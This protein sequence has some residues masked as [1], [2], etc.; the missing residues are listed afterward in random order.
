MTLADMVDNQ[1]WEQI[2]QDIDSAAKMQNILRLRGTG[3]GAVN[4]IPTS[5]PP[6]DME[7]YI[8][9]DHNRSEIFNR[10]APGLE[11]MLVANATEAN[12]RA[13]KATL[14]DLT[15]YPLLLLF[16]ETLTHQVLWRYYGK[17]Y[18]LVP[19]DIRVTDRVLELTER[20]KHGEALTVDEYRAL[21][22]D[23]PYPDPEIGK[24]PFV[25]LKTRSFFTTPPDNPTG[26]AGAT[27]AALPVEAANNLTDVTAQQGQASA[28][29][30]I[31]PAMMEL[32]KWERLANRSAVK[33]IDF[34]AHNIPARVADS[35]RDQL[36]G[37]G[38]DVDDIFSMARNSL[39]SENSTILTLA[40]AINRLA[41]KK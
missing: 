19:D 15:V 24:I 4:W 36:R 28:K 8:G 27:A 6:K 26:D 5:V 12:A 13:G 30:D 29:A 22:K 17:Q 3:S 33:A 37:G 2:G 11:S 21:W 1:Q 14:I 35:V 25:Q 9:R 32:E 20:E 38:V 18:K 23:D 7:F 39:Q 41:D 10:L 34:M 40:A 16:C 31:H